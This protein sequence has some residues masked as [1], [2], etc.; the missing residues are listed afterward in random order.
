MYSCAELAETTLDFISHHFLEVIQH[1]EFLSLHENQITDLLKHDSLQVVSEEQV[2]EAALMW[3][4]WLPEERMQSTCQLM[5]HLKLALL[6]TSYLEESVL[7]VDFVRNCPKCQDLVA[8]AIRTRTMNRLQIDSIHIRGVARGIYVLG[9]RN[10]EDCQ[11]K[12]MEKFDV[13]KSRWIRMVCLP[14]Q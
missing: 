14:M 8:D 5:H 4:N 6:D 2:F 1:E 10:S 7:R 9:G 11:L 13:L 3:I 12:T